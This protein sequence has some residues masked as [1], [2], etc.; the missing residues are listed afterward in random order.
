MIGCHGSD[1]GTLN[2]DRADPGDSRSETSS[3]IDGFSKRHGG[4]PGTEAGNKRKTLSFEDKIDNPE[5]VPDLLKLNPDGSLV[6][7]ALAKGR[8]M[9]DP[10]PSTK[11]NPAVTYCF[12]WHLKDWCFKTCNRTADHVVHEAA[13]REAMVSWLKRNF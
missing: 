8:R 12:S 10:P 6:R 3:N 9:K 7:G 5:R 2:M 4:Q 1:A 11:H 13:D